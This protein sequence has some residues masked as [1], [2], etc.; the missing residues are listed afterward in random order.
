MDGTINKVS[1]VPG[2]SSAHLSNITRLSWPTAIGAGGVGARK[3]TGAGGR[4]LGGGGLEKG[5]NEKEK[6]EVRFG[7]LFWAELLS[8]N[9]CT[10]R[11]YEI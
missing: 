10:P 6:R 7:V 1:R 11:P 9:R 3:M 5:K 8:G 2:V 4:C